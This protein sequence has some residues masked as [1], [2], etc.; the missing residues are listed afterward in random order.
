MSLENFQVRFN[1]GPITLSLPSLSF[2]PLISLG[3][4]PFTMKLSSH[5]HELS[6]EC[7]QE[8]STLCLKHGFTMYSSSLGFSFLFIYFTF[9]FYYLKFSLQLE[10]IVAFLSKSMKSSSFWALAYNKE[11]QDQGSSYWFHRILDA[12]SI[13]YLLSSA[14][15]PL[16]R[17]GF[18]HLGL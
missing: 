14:Q 10:Y 15:N 5:S 11:A 16:F 3:F 13:A 8:F 7:T 12:K 17:K 6:L 18:F 4:G 2:L 9:F 1:E